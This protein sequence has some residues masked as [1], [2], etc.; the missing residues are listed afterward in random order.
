M[1]SSGTLSISL[2]HFLAIDF[3]SDL[4]CAHS[5]FKS[6][7]KQKPI[8]RGFENQKPI[9][10]PGSPFSA[11]VVNV[12]YAHPRGCMFEPLSSQKFLHYINFSSL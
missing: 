1:F 12:P 8:F 3:L 2:L 11:H 6:V 9:L 4:N 5:E 7:A 10:S